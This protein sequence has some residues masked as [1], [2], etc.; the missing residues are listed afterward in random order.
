SVNTRCKLSCHGITFYA[1]S[2]EICIAKHKSIGFVHTILTGIC[3][4]GECGKT[5]ESEIYRRE[6]ENPWYD[7]YNPQDKVPWPFECQFISVQDK[8]DK[9]FVSTTCS[10]TCKDGVVK[11][12]KEGT[13][14]ILS[15]IETEDY[16]ANITVGKCHNGRCVSDG[17][18]YK[19]QVEKEL[20]ESRYEE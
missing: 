17:M 10:V 19:I 16:Y 20:V 13:P 9:V 1:G 3:E 7:I 11:T 5:N 12:R 6:L 2:N 8:R 14:C 18:D 15:S 4:N